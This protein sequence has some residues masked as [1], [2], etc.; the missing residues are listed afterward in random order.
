MKAVFWRL[1]VVAWLV[2]LGIGGI[3]VAEATDNEP[4]RGDTAA[5]RHTPFAVE[6][7]PLVTAPSGPL[8][9]G[10]WREGLDAERQRMRERLRYDGGAYRNPAFAWVPSCYSCC[11]AMMCDQRLYDPVNRRYTID[12][13]LDEGAREFGGYDAV[14]LWQ[15]YPRIGFDERNQ[16][17]F[18]RDMPGGLAGLR[19]LGAVMHRRGVKV[20]IDYNPWDTG[21]RREGKSDVEMLVEMAAA[22]DA[23]G[24]FLDTLH[25]GMQE[26]RGRLD[27]VRPGVV[28]ESEL[29]LPVERIGD[30]HM[31]WAQWF[32]DSEAPG[33]LWNKW[34]ERRHMMHQI[35]RWNGDHTGELHMAW[36]NG[37]GMLVWENVFGSWVP[38]S[39]RDRSILRSML[40][41]Q[42]RYVSLF[43]GESWTPLVPTEQANVYASLWQ[44]DGIRLWTFVNRSGQRIEGT[45]LRVP[46]VDGQRYYDLVT[47]RELDV[48]AGVDALLW[49]SLGPRGVGAYVAGTAEALGADFRTFL[50]AQ[51]AIYRGA[52]WDA[53][54]GGLDEKLRPVERTRRYARNEIPA[55]M[56]AVRAARLR[57]KT[58]Y[59]NRECGFYSVEGRQPPVHPSRDL[60]KIVGFEREVSLSPYAIDLTPVTNGQYARFLQQTG[61]APRDKENF[62][63]HWSNGEVPPGREDH[64]VVY[65][66]LEDARA[67][68]RW[69]GKRLPTEEEWQYAAQGTDGRAYPWGNDWQEGRCND[70]GG[71]TAVMAFP[72]GRSPFGCYDMCGNTWEWTES[73]RSDGRTRFCILKGG[74]W[75]KARGSDWYADGGPQ[76]CDFAAKFLLMWPGLD[77]CATV[78]F[79]CVVDLADGP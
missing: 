46:Y 52:D 4:A 12:A 18:Y 28:L 30:H 74:S 9:W 2:L 37:S 49:C 69:A 57:M 3:T 54:A 76:P 51:A 16:F 50:D 65:V 5:S 38:W 6:V 29:T 24:I 58:R 8:K 15:A 47:G 70:G 55:G 10:A 78:S 25:E 71:T 77:R 1:S 72:Q 62:L 73:E 66:E 39:P 43:S 63:K 45:M 13:F 31:S 41:I 68:A 26:L 67:Y 53:S 40:P 48:E 17:D 79:R 33:V 59:R 19:E 21:T 34:F 56:V 20:F 75:Y 14:V 32:A 7:K 61:Y 44:G 36:M 22:I 23:D 60:H 64:P 42:R 11:F 27:A 35:Q